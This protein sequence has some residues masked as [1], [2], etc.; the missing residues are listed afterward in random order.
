MYLEQLKAEQKKWLPPSDCLH[1]CSAG[2]V[3]SFFMLDQTRQNIGGLLVRVKPWHRLWTNTN[4]SAVPLTRHGNRVSPSSF[5]CLWQCFC[6]PLFGLSGQS[7]WTQGVADFCHSFAVCQ[8]VSCLPP[9]SRAACTKLPGV[10]ILW[11]EQQPCKRSFNAKKLC[12]AAQPILAGEKRYLHLNYFRRSQQQYLH[13]RTT[14][15]Q[16]GKDSNRTQSQSPEFLQTP[17]NSYM[18]KWCSR[19]QNTFDLRI[20]QKMH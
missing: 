15:Q 10:L 2:W 12:K 18:V 5:F 4:C 11:N 16:R 1:S 13:L 9:A 7:C 6:Q 20:V 14:H 8:A 17:N 19:G 3:M